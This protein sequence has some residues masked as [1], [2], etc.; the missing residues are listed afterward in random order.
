M[1]TYVMHINP[2]GKILAVTI[3]LMTQAKYIYKFINYNKVC[4]T[5]GII[6]HR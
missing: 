5:L 1:I 6:K 3:K 4:K 2:F